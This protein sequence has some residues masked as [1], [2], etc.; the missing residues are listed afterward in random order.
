MPYA[1]R[2]SRIVLASVAGLLGFA[3]Y[4]G[5]VVTLADSIGLVPWAVRAL[6]FA[7]AGIAWVFPARWLMLWA[8]RR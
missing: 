3:L 5:A 6:Y 2:M 7:V 8:A 1:R 4:V